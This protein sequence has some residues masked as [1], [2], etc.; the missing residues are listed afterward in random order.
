MIT[1]AIIAIIKISDMIVNWFVLEYVPV[2][3]VNALA[4]PLHE[5]IPIKLVIPIYVATYLA[6]SIPTKISVVIW[7]MIL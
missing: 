2:L 6:S 5:V 3:I 1:I 7:L 4:I